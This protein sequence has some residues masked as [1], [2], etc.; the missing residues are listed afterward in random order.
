MHI[1][2]LV[3]VTGGRWVKVMFL[4]NYGLVMPYKDIDLDQYIGS[5]SGLLSDSTKP[6]PEP[7][8]TNY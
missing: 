2:A 8:F 4:S 6:L 7:I 1:W 3:V 5:D